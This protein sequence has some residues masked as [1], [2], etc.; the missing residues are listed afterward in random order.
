MTDPVVPTFAGPKLTDRIQECVTVDD[1]HKKMHFCELPLFCTAD[2]STLMNVGCWDLLGISSDV[3]GCGNGQLSEIVILSFYVS[4]VHFWTLVFR[5]CVQLHLSDR[6]LSSVRLTASHHHYHHL[7]RHHQHHPQLH[8]PSFSSSSRHHVLHHRLEHSLRDVGYRRCWHG[9]R[10]CGCK[11]SNRV[12]HWRHAEE[13][14]V[15]GYGPASS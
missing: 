6:L 4:V 3:A 12:V 5:I 1:G 11:C 7:Q 9:C 14:E 13:I 2:I 8:L 15:L 10:F